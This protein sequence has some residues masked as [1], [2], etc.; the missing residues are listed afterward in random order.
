MVGCGEVECS[1]LERRR[2][3]EEEGAGITPNPYYAT[4][5]LSEA[6]A[7]AVKPQSGGAEVHPHTETEGTT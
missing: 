2:V 6:M 1:V 3:G 5:L 7:T 4:V